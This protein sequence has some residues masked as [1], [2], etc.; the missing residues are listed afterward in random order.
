MNDVGT[1]GHF[2][3]FG[4]DRFR[5]ADYLNDGTAFLSSASKP[6]FDDDIPF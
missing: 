2:T 6:D 1:V 4:A 3:P 5:K